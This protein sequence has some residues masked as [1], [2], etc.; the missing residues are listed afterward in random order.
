MGS[1]S[2]FWISGVGILGRQEVKSQG[3]PVDTCNNE[4][5]HTYIILG[6]D[7]VTHEY[8]AA[9]LKQLSLVEPGYHNCNCLVS[10]KL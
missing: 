9:F 10:V 1:I 8:W 4:F 7:S 3:L 6:S 2:L 5:R